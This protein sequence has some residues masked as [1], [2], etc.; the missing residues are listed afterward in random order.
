QQGADQFV[1][2]L[3]ERA[4][5]H[6]FGRLRSIASRDRF[7]RP[8]RADFAHGSTLTTGCPRPAIVTG[9]KK[10]A[11]RGGP[12]TT[13]I[14]SRGLRPW[15]G[16]VAPPG[17]ALDQWPAP[18]ERHVLARGVSPWRCR[19]LNYLGIRTRTLSCRSSRRS[20]RKSISPRWSATSSSS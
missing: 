19:S 1:A 15:L 16:Y 2:Q 20:S 14:G 8:A 6:C 5:E 7:G 11:N 10:V 12:R 4:H 13:M 18:E 3:V 9:P 17:L